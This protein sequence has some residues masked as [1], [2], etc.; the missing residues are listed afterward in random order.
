MTS[1]RPA[2]SLTRPWSDAAPPGDVGVGETSSAVGSPDRPDGS[3]P[4]DPHPLDGPIASATSTG[5][6]RR[7]PKPAPGFSQCKG[8]AEHEFRCFRVRSGPSLAGA[9]S[10]TRHELDVRGN[11]DKRA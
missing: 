3:S 6:N 2:S 8:D 10:E 1:T 4:L 9:P 5:I 7:N 11:R